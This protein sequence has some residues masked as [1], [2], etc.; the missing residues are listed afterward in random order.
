MGVALILSV[1]YVQGKT[2]EGWSPALE[3]RT[4]G[5]WI[6]IFLYLAASVLCWWAF[7][8]ESLTRGWRSPAGEGT[9]KEIA[10][11]WLLVGGCALLLGITRLLDLGNLLTAWGRGVAHDEGWYGERR[12]LQ[13]SMLLAL[14]LGAIAA[15]VAIAQ[16]SRNHP[17]SLR[18]AYFGT[19]FVL[20]LV[21]IR[22]C[23]WH[24]LD[25]VL[26]SEWEGFRLSWLLESGG[27]GLV[28]GAA[29]YFRPTL[30]FPL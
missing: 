18:L 16:R 20:C 19:A 3:D 4:L 13:V 30:G 29:A 17:G 27:A 24:Y 6:A 12:L 22:A 10:V 11:G 23:S 7:R 14:T 28:A 21:A 25:L 8:R 26:E 15:V 5:A 9:S 1:L 2:V